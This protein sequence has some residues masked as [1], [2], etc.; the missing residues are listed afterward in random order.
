MKNLF[1]LLLLIPL[2]S[3]AQ[4]ESNNNISVVSSERTS[5]LYRGIYNPIK[6]AVPNAK[7]FI[8]S[9][10]GLTKIDSLGNYNFDV[11]G[12]SRNETTIKIKAVM[13]DG[14]TINE[15]KTFEIRDIKGQLALINGE[16]CYGD[17]SCCG[18]NHGETGNA[19]KD[20][21]SFPPKFANR[22]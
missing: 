11:T 22:T 6:I 2:V 18:R 5:I 14:S 3:L 19:G 20:I 15:S 13:N 12:V 4:A 9:A 7:S 21:G 1:Y 10:P 8:A 16:N 17:Y